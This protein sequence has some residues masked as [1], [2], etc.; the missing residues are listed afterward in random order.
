MGHWIRVLNCKSYGK[1]VP[2]HDCTL[3]L[4][5]VF[6]WAWASTPG[7]RM[8]HG[9]EMPD[10]LRSLHIVLGDR[11]E[12]ARLIGMA[13]ALEPISCER[14][15]TSHF[16]PPNRYVCF[17]NVINWFPSSWCSST[18][19]CRICTMHTCGII[20]TTKQHAVVRRFLY[21]GDSCAKETPVKRTFLDKARRLLW[22]GHMCQF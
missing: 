6:P 14:R 8:A 4:W 5:S 11:I 2:T 22:Q 9:K 19:Q 16:T 12:P 7:C 1:H 13:P 20:K 17:H 3:A 21:Q 15:F 18:W 10:P